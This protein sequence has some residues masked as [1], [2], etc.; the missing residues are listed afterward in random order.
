MRYEARI[1]KILIA[2]SLRGI[3]PA[4]RMPLI[5]PS[6]HNGAKGAWLCALLLISE[7]I[8]V[9]LQT[10]RGVA[11]VGGVPNGRDLLESACS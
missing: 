10:E 5:R 8:F 3:S 11:F 6:T 4:F 7:G 9:F 1:H 2:I